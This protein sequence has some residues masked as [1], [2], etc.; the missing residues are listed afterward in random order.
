[1]SSD[2]HLICVAQQTLSNAP[3]SLLA[4]LPIITSEH[5]FSDLD[6]GNDGKGELYITLSEGDSESFSSLTFGNSP[7]VDAFIQDLFCLAQSTPCILPSEGQFIVAK[8]DYLS[9]VPEDLVDDCVVCDTLEDFA[10]AF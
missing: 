4:H 3:V 10:Q 7:W 9:E 8:N 6:Y 1:M 2:I 5:G